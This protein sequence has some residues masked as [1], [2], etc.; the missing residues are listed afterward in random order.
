MNLAQLFLSNRQSSHDIHTEDRPKT[1]EIQ[2]NQKKYKERLGQQP[3]IHNTKL[4]QCILFLKINF[5]NSNKGDFYLQ[6]LAQMSHSPFS[7]LL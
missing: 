1:I 7:L 6:I 3:I 4:F 5:L 2:S